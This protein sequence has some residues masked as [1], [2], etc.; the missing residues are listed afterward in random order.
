[1]RGLAYGRLSRDEDIE[2][3]SL[4]NQE[5][6]VVNAI[7]KGNNTVVDVAMDDNYTGM[8]FERP[9]IK[10]MF[11]LARNGKIDAVFVKDLSRL[12]R[13][14]TLTL[15]CIDKLKLLG[16]RVISVTENIDSFNDSDDLLIG[17]KGLL[18]DYYSRD[19]QKKVIYGFRQKQQEGLVMIPPMGYFKDKNTNEVEIVEEAAEIIRTIFKLYLEGYGLKAIARILNEKGMKSPAYYQLK[20]IGKKQ[21]YNKPKITSRFLWDYSSVKRILKN[22]FYCGTV[23]NH[24]NERSRITKRQ[25]DV[26]AEEQFRHE[27]MVPAIIPREMWERTQEFLNAKVRKNVRASENKPCHKYSGLLQCSDCGCSFVAKVRKRAAGKST[28]EKRLENLRNSIA[29]TEI[30]IQKILMERIE[31]KQNSDMYDKMIETRR[32]DIEK[33]KKEISEIENLDKTIKERKATLKHSIELL[34]DI[35]AENNISNANLHLMF[36][37]I[38]IEETDEGLNLDLRLKSPFIS[39]KKEPLLKKYMIVDNEVLSVGA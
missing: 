16:V 2:L 19:I 26:P 25:I 8:N 36:D 18:N 12:G 37:K 23:V 7:K 4:K 29:E 6:I 31:D 28:T 21:G 17:F 38:V 30:E 32:D 27:D 9:G 5:A 15:D 22:E 14:R 35:I 1:M 20:L 13:H 33:F 3:E 11:E 39:K 24:K 34:D 10:K